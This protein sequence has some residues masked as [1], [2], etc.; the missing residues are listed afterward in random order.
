MFTILSKRAAGQP[1]HFL[2]SA[3]KNH[4][5][6]RASNSISAVSISSIRHQSSSSS[7][8]DNDNSNSPDMEPLS[9]NEAPVNASFELHQVD[10]AHGSFFALHRPLL[11]IAN[12]PMFA[13]SN[14]MM[15]EEDYEGKSLHAPFFHAPVF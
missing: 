13:N 15:N 7:S 12:G 2:K 10:L 4:G 8:R 3:A 14:N 9:T 1:A 5:H 11:G 6:L